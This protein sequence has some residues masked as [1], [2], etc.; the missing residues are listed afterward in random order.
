VSDP[1]I[2]RA[3]DEAARAPHTVPAELLKRIA[4]SI[5]PT[6]EAVRPLPPTWMLTGALVLIGAAVAL[7]GAAHAGFQ[8][9]AALGSGS[10]VAVFATL[11]VLTCVAA[12]Q[13]V[14]E[15]I[16]GSP[17]RLSAAGLLVATSVALLAVFASLFHDY[18]TDHFVP[19]GL[20]C[21]LTGLLYAIP[22]GLLG[23]WLL[24]RGWVVNCVAAGLVAGV[25]AGLAGVTLLELHCSNLEALHVLV[26]HTLVV[27]VSGA[28]GAILGWALRAAN[29]TRPADST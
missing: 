25:L 5:E 19:A 14:R 3:L 29:Q 12:G 26:W 16:P 9:F 11:T 4:G 23:W 8:G 15:W 20:A 13:L 17:R 18:R 2:D 1:K 22:A 7:A 10:R 27:P 21:L 6:L 24:R 28:A